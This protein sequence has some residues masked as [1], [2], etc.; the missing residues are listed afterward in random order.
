M[1]LMP[2]TPE[3]EVMD[4]E[5]EARDYDA[6]DHGDVNANF[7]VDLLALRARPRSVLDAGTGTALIAIELCRRAPEPTVEAIDLA[8]PMLA[9]ATRNVERA[10][11]GGRIRLARRDATATG[12]PGAAFDTVMSNSLAHHIPEPLD[13]FTELLRLV[14]DGGLLFV[15]DL[16]RPENAARVADLAERYAKVQ[17]G[18]S[19]S[20]AGAV[21]ARQRALFVASLHAA[22]TADEVRARV[23]RLGIPGSAV[24]MTSDRHWT[25]AHVRS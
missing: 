21:H 2:R 5:Q 11:M 16:A 19:S 24:R 15:R 1:S 8:G 23:A 7:C 3:P 22:L 12:M 13:L 6:M 9:R 18:D 17:E 20:E 10:G 25:L 14:S 4:S